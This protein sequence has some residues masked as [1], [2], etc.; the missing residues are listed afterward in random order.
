MSAPRPRILDELGAELVRAARAE[1]A[2][3]HGDRSARSGRRT[4]G[5]G[6]A[7]PA[8][9]G[10]LTRA[11][12]A[13][14]LAFGAALLL[15]AGAV[16][17]GLVIGRGD[18]IPPAPPGQVPAE[19][20]PVPGTARLNG[21]DVPDPDGGPPWDIRTS[22]SRTG[23]TCATVGQVLD[24]ELGLVGL[25]R[26]FRAL[27]A[28]AADTCSTPQRSGATLAGARAFRG[29]GRLS[30]ITVVNGVA[31]PGV[32]R[33][34]V[35]AGGRSQPLEL[36]PD[37]AFLAIFRGQPEQLRP[38]VVLTEADGT[39]TTLRF[40]DT[41]EY[42]APD[43]SGG[44][45]W[46]VS[47]E[48][49]RALPGLR[50]VQA[51]RQR[52]PDSPTPLPSGVG[53]ANVMAA[54]VPLRCGAEDRAF[55]DVRRFVPRNQTHGETSW[56]GFNASRT[57]AWGATPNADADVRLLAPGPARRIPVDPRTHAFVVVLD[58]RVDPRAVRLTVDGQPLTPMAGV[59]G[60]RGNTL[61]PAP[62]TPPAWRSV[63]SVV[64]RV[65][66]SDPFVADRGTVRITRRVAD[67]TGG[68]P[69]AL[70]RW[71]A[72]VNARLSGGAHALLC[73]QVGHPAPDGALVLPGLDGRDRKLSLQGETYCNRPE[74]L[75]KHAAG[76][77]VRVEV[78]D[79]SSADPKPVRAVVAGLLGKGVRSAELLGAGAPRP[80]ELGPDG[81][82]LLVLPGDQAPDSVRVRQTRADGNVRT[83]RTFALAEACRL[84]PGRNVRV[85]DPDGGPSWTYGESTVD[86]THCT[87]TGRV[88]ADRL[89]SIS[90]T[91][92]TTMFGPSSFTSAPPGGGS[93]RRPRT[94]RL[95]FTVAGPGNEPPST[96]ADDAPLAPQIARRTQPGRTIV[97]GSAPP[98][99]TAVTI[100]T[101]RDVRTVK[102]VAS[103][104]MAVYDGPFYTGEIV[105][106]ARRAD[107]TT[108]TER[109]PAT[110]R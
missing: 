103:L 5:H 73:Y 109:R 77:F 24:G 15:A 7:G 11:P 40:A 22:R 55:L 35:V 36:G 43:P 64:E 61:A 8:R 20:A 4:R 95:D 75:E 76:A 101:P 38:R 79:P 102:P 13:V 63:D 70:R 83:T 89:A 74:W 91:D 57:V 14:V 66:I 32:R 18:P 96:D 50:C 9:G 10:W 31:A 93:R 100:R 87:F 54:S 17:A 33:A 16:A 88:I 65:G 46:T 41:G 104:F 52:G 108:L 28:G 110:Y 78:D 82:F 29:G 99:V 68:A 90:P 47:R 94:P 42:L 84:Q 49:E 56:W 67:P 92:G 59:T 98:D 72:R 69:W 44:A 48:T 21:L 27:P 85:A 1:E 2:A 105:V 80:L 58:G 37:H 23:A 86:G 106:T 45:P 60:R 34:V 81:T 3:T 62:A 26:R 19:L 97:T 12:R 107:G 6:S 53:L 39:T 25:D 51:R 30:A 71:R